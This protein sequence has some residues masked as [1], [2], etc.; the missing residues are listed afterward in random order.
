MNEEGQ[1]EIKFHPRLALDRM[2]R[3][4]GHRAVEPY[5]ERGYPRPEP[6]T[7]QELQALVEEDD[8]E[9]RIRAAH[10][11]DCPDSVRRDIAFQVLSE[12]STTE[13]DD[14]W[15]IYELAYYFLEDA[16]RID[17]DPEF[18]RIAHRLLRDP[19]YASFRAEIARNAACP[20]DVYVALL[21]DED[22]W[23]NE[24]P[25]D[26]V[27]HSI[28]DNPR[29]PPEHARARLKERLLEAGQS[30]IDDL[31]MRAAGSPHA[32]A[33]ILLWL[34]VD[35]ALDAG[36]WT[37]AG[38]A[39]T[40]A[41]RNNPNLPSQIMASAEG[42]TEGPPQWRCLLAS[43][44]DS[45]DTWAFKVMAQDMD[46]HVRAAIANH[47]EAPHEILERLAVDDSI[48]VRRA[49]WANPGSTEVMRASAAIAGIE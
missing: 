20:D 37:P 24:P 40:L 26:E 25:F 11:A 47:E 12:L 46:D 5:V 23:V 27:W 6:L 14:H 18:L 29:Q 7:A 16:L 49:V 10:H 32:D 44:L 33:E 42:L 4:G 8:L 45:Q 48:W 17:P 35:D 2:L 19:D 39:T 34:L 3:A 38:V 28:L 1:H 9:S 21:E 13:E 36:S 30:P 22:V 41:V 43:G 31:R 15:E